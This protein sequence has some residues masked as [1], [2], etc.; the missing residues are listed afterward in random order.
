MN[1]S[2]IETLVKQTKEKDKKATENL[3]KEFQPT[4]NYFINKYHIPGYEKQDLIND[5]IQI[6]LHAAT[7]YNLEKHRF[8]SYGINAIKNNLLYILRKAL[9]CKNH[10]RLFYNDTEEAYIYQTNENIIDQTDYSNLASNKALI[11]TLLK[12]LNENEQ[13]LLYLIFTKDI[14]AIEYAKRKNIS[15]TAV[16]KRKGKLLAK[17]KPKLHDCIK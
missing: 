11:K 10:E 4:I 16:A 12:D 8:V 15:Y 17:L 6:L 9:K 3:I 14:K 1:Y 13:E 2:Y 5:S 7:I